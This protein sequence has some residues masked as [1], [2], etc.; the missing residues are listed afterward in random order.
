MNVL[1]Y[2]LPIASLFL[3]PTDAVLPHTVDQASN[4]EVY[5]ADI[6]H[7]SR[8]KPHSRSHEQRNAS[9]ASASSNPVAL[10]ECNNCVV[11]FVYCLTAEDTHRSVAI[12]SKKAESFDELKLSIYTLQLY[13]PWFN[14]VYL[15]MSGPQRL[16]SWAANDSRIEM[17]DQH[18]LLP[19]RN[20]CPVA[21]DDRSCQQVIHS[22]PGLSQHYVSIFEDSFLVKPVSPADFFTAEGRPILT[23][24][25]LDQSVSSR[26]ASHIPPHTP[27]PMLLT[28]SQHLEDQCFAC[29]GWSQWFDFVRSSKQSLE[30]CGS[31]AKQ[32]DFF[33]RRLEYDVPHHASQ[34]S[35]EC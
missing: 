23:P 11:D 6:N 34:V 31:R 18:R 29:C 19:G 5:S 8:R 15:L 13:A 3:S 27:M 10:H 22:I 35:N 4:V 24:D 16:P 25:I 33:Q 7:L 1:S 28:F 30:C 17:V 20:T 21:S 26:Q 9:V 2:A 32:G 12:N 14:K